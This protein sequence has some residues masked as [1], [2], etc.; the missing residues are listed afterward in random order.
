MKYIITFWLTGALFTWGIAYTAPDYEK[1]RDAYIYAAVFLWPA[2]L[3]TSVG[4]Y[5]DWSL[6]SEEDT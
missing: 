4:I 5:Y 6:V 1:N 2:L 3:G